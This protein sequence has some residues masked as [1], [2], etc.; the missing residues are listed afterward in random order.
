MR[1]R[2]GNSRASIGWC[3]LW[4]SAGRWKHLEATTCWPQDNVRTR[5]QFTTPEYYK[6]QLKTQLVPSASSAGSQNESICN[7]KAKT[8]NLK[9][10]I[11]KWSN[12]VAVCPLTRCRC[13]YNS[14][15]LCSCRRHFYPPENLKWERKN[16]TK[17]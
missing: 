13:R 4:R 7:S 2:V 14:I 5:T 10:K 16:S 15:C 12:K 1:R 17:D 9:K 8:E 3:R 6:K 11:N